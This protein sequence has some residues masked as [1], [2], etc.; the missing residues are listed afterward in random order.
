[1]V[2]VTFGQREES[3][4]WKRAWIWRESPGNW[5]GFVLHLVVSSW[6]F[7]FWWVSELLFM[8]SVLFWWLWQVWL[9]ERWEVGTWLN[10]WFYFIFIYC[11]ERRG[12]WV[13]LLFHKTDSQ[14]RIEGKWFEGIINTEKSLR[15]EDLE[16][17]WK[18][19]P[20]INQRKEE[21]YAHVSLWLGSRGSS[22]L[23]ALFSV[24]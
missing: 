12:T 17:S 24:N 1:M 19:C 11:F 22:C 5:Q 2:E 21:K 18:N 7:I 16:F 13:I 3:K 20:L 6:V 14:K 9:L 10:V 8:F 4:D 15:R 23:M